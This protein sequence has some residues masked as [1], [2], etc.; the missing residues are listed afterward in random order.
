MKIL[1]KIIEKL[2][3][4]YKFK[5][6]PDKLYIEMMMY[7]KLP[8]KCNIQDPITFNEKLNWLKLNDRNP[9]YVKLVD[10]YEVKKLVGNIMGEEY[11]IP[12][13][14]VWEKF[15][16]I[17]FNSLPEQFV[18]K[19]THDSG[20]IVFVK[21]KKRFNKKSAKYKIEKSLKRNFY[22]LGRE[23]PYKNVK[24]RIIAE[25]LMKQNGDE[26]INDYKFFCF[27]GVPKF[28]KIDFDRQK[29]HK[30]NY[31]DLS[32]N[33]LNFGEKICPPDPDKILEMPKNLKRMIEF[34]GKLSSGK[35]FL[36]VDFYE[37]DNKLYFGELTFYPSSGFGE[38]VPNE[39]D[40]KIGSY[41]EL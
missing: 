39:W 34:A 6:I 20:G 11:I 17:D 5:F 10:K 35:K 7:S 38:F 33:V 16:D 26:E 41:L 14:G 15:D 25:P 22:Y 12:T 27:D 1:K 18:L 23:W 9:E 2:L 29:N 19:C 3:T 31:Y 37:I 40:E 8:Y 30:A 32:G 21:E 13:L 24:P 28:F 36:R 4:K